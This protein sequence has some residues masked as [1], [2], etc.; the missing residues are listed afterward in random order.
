MFILSVLSKQL[1]E[2]MSESSFFL[3][4]QS[5]V[6]PQ[7]SKQFNFPNKDTLVEFPNVIS[8]VKIRGL[9][10]FIILEVTV[11]MTVFPCLSYQHSKEI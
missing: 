7:S 1:T 8:C 3:I 9:V 11:S 5:R 2:F 10:F 6:D 4:F